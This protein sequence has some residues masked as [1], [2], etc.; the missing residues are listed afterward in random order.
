MG[1]RSAVFGLVPGGRQ[2]AG[3]LAAGGIQCAALVGQ[4]RGTL[5]ND[6]QRSAAV[7]GALPANPALDSGWLFR[8]IG[9]RSA[10]AAAGICRAK[11]TTSR[12]DS[13]QPYDSIHARVRRAGGV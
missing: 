5:A 6:A 12:H 8:G 2:A 10:F 9:G 1:L 7:A 11:T 13:R 4:I 3:V